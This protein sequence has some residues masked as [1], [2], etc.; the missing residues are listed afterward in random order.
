MLRIA[1]FVAFGLACTVGVVVVASCTGDDPNLVPLTD[2]GG[3]EFDSAIGDGGPGRD[4]TSP[5]GDAEGG[6]CATP[7]GKLVGSTGYPF[8][9]TNQAVAS[10]S[11]GGYV[12]AG[13]FRGSATFDPNQ[14]AMVGNSTTEDTTAVRF[15]P[16]R[17]VM[18]QVHFGGTGTERFQGVAVD[19]KDDVYVTG[20]FDSTAFSIGTF[21][22]TNA[23]G[24]ELGIVAKLDGKTGNPLWAKQ[25][26]PGS[27]GFGCSAIDFDSGRLVVSCSMGLTQAYDTAT[28]SATLLGSQ[29]SGASVYGLDPATGNALWG[30]GLGTGAGADASVSTYVSS[31]DVTPTG[32]VVAGTFSG[33]SLTERQ[34]NAITVPQIGTK[35]NGFV[36]EM[37]AQNPA[38][39]L[40]A[41]GFGDATNVGEVDNVVAAGATVPGIIVGATFSGTVDFGS[42]AHTS[43]G[44]GDVIA[45]ML[46]NKAG[47][48]SWEK[49]FGGTNS[50]SVGRVWFDPCGRPEMM[51]LSRSPLSAQ[52]SVTIPAPQASGV[53]SILTKLTPDGT[54]LWAKGVTPGGNPDSNGINQYD[55][56]V[57]PTNGNSIIVGDFRGAVDFGDGTAVTAS[58]GSHSYF[59]EYGP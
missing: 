30:K 17:S 48:P 11:N 9:G 27:F 45:M 58:G 44:S 10:T 14:P 37:S 43:A 47:A 16:D 15:N 55:L 42:G 33:G 35:Q 7:T 1:S 59:V 54:L 36:T 28:G 18:W 32:V 19:D 6:G 34:T 12:I 25:F 52:D 23:T 20:T 8:V 22:F 3:A 26:M 29:V 46:R 50:E 5:L 41:K 31:V 56:W 51:F 40:W 21:A 2:D 49:L 53:A 24:A 38:L 13:Y 39:P 4:A 57:N